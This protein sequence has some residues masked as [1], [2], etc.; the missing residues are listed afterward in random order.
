MEVLHLEVLFFS[1]MC[2]LVVKLSRYYVV[3]STH[4][5]GSMKIFSY[6]QMPK[7]MLLSYMTFCRAFRSN[8]RYPRQVSQLFV[9]ITPSQRLDINNQSFLG[10]VTTFFV[11]LKP[12][13]KSS[14]ASIST[15]LRNILSTIS[16]NIDALSNKYKKPCSSAAI[17]QILQPFLRNGFHN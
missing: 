12:V 16:F 7:R 10:S 1:W 5:W 17:W 2:I 15:F 9:F 13:Y 14:N 6:H 8:F 11:T 4:P 3:F